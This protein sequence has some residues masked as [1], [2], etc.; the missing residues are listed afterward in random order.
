MDL[1][2]RMIEVAS[3][4]CAQIITDGSPEPCFCGV[5]PG[6]SVVLAYA[7]DCESRDGMAWVRL[8]SMYPSSTLGEQ[9][10]VP[11]NCTGGIGAEVEL[12]IVR[13]YPVSGDG[14]E[15]PPAVL[16]EIV[17]QQVKDAMTLYRTVMPCFA[18]RWARL[19][20]VIGGARFGPGGGFG[21]LK[22]SSGLAWSSAWI[23]ARAGATSEATAVAWKS[24]GAAAGSGAARLQ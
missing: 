16:E 21:K 12:G 13:S 18:N 15:P 7:T 6:D 2:D 1:A 4:L 8:I 19:G 10:F 14:E 3:C 9:A 5:V 24:Q 11:G 17:R 23:T 22:G 20:M